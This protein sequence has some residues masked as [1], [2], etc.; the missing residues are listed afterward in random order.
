MDGV[1]ILL[2]AVGAA[3]LVTYWHSRRRG[4]RRERLMAERLSTE[5]RQWL[6]ANWESWDDLPAETRT[7][8]EGLTRVF[9]DEKVF[10]ACGGLEE[11]TDEMRVVVAA[12]ACLLWINQRGT[13]Y[14]ALQAILMYPDAYRVRNDFGIEHVRLG[15]SWSRGTVVLAWNSV[16]SGG[17]DD[18]D[19]HNLVFHEFAHQLDTLNGAADGF[20]GM[21]REGDFS[22]WA[23][24][25]QRDYE[26]L[27]ERYERR[28][29]AVLD[30]YGTKNPAEFFAVATETFFEKPKP[31]KEEHPELYA[32]MVTYFANNP[33]DWKS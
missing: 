31:F 8:V 17:R 9:L 10:E 22:E 26:E 18:D 25:C 30:F 11:V 27:C 28:Q 3:L 1:L 32:L 13:P 19:G 12:Q 29:P 14:P 6:R 5:Q 16:Q 15:E 21:P 24:V 23:E 20:P 7:K 4:Q 2:A 33:M